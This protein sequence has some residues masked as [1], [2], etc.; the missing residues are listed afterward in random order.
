MP[1]KINQTELSTMN[2]EELLETRDVRK[3]TKV[4][5]PY[6]YFYKR[7]IDGKYSNFVEF[8]D[9][10][11]DN[12]AFGSCVEAEHQALSDIRL[13]QQLH[14]TPNEGEEGIFAIAVEPGNYI[15]FEQLLNDNP[16][17]VAK[18]DFVSTILGE[19]FDI[20][21]ELNAHDIYHVCYA[22]TNI[23]VRKGDSSIRL[24]CHGSFY[25]K[26]DAD[27]LYEGVEDYV[28]P[29]FFTGA[30]ADARSDV[31]SLGMFI[32]KLYES[33]AMPFR[34][35]R[36]V[37]KAISA[38]PEQRYYSVDEMRKDIRKMQNLQRS[39]LLAACAAAIALCIAGI[40]FYMLPDTQPV[41]FVK[42]VEEPIP[43][44]LFEDNMDDYLGIGEEMDSA[45]IARIIASKRLNNDSISADEKKLRE[46][47]AKAEAIF[48]KQF[49]KAADEIIS[50]VYNYKSMNGE[51]AVFAAKSKEM[52]E[53]LAKKQMELT[54]NSSLSA[55]RTEVIA[56]EIIEHITKQK[57]ESLDKDYLG[58][59]ADKA[60]QEVETITSNQGQAGRVS[61]QK[62]GTTDNDYLGIRSVKSNQGNSSSTGNTA[63]TGS[64]TTQESNANG[65]K[66][67]DYKKEIKREEDEY[68]LNSVSGN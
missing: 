3:T 55:D 11:A 20:A 30:A 16:A 23:L 13:K 54:K 28:A 7:Q 65:K 34:L 53:Q 6:G 46:Y 1:D 42:P 8:H 59:K 26:I 44:D 66:G 64:T 24:L 5:L 56:A 29:E 9:E 33:S 48:R 47:N 31:Y 51:Q 40:F 12:I 41:E 32:K 36:A 22:P 43:D 68:I 67:Y 19:L 45:T 38:D 61:S 63:G 49:T 60:A 37:E 57:M 35:K 2:F 21:S 25:Q 14:Y 52:T 10:V 27:V 17:I 62:T 58:L 18:G 15:T 39:G 4:R 50:K